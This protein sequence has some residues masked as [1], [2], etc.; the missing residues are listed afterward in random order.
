MAEPTFGED[1]G[2]KLPLRGVMRGPQREPWAIGMEAEAWRR[3][4]K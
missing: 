1:V 2:R 3:I 4:G